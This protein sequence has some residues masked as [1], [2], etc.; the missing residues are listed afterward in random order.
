MRKT[1]KMYIHIQD[2]DKTL[3]KKNGLKCFTCKNLNSFLLKRFR[4]LLVLKPRAY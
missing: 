1:F 4:C 3:T 2:R